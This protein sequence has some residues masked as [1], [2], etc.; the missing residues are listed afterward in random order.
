MREIIYTVDPDD[1]ICIRCEEEEEGVKCSRRRGHP[2]DTVTVKVIE[3]ES[4]I[5]VL[6][7]HR[8]A[9]GGRYFTW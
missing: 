1:R 4:E 5:V 9:L 3:D 7:N 8:G 6:F 2:S